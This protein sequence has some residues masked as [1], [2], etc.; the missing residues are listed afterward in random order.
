MVGSRQLGVVGSL[1]AVTTLWLCVA[2]A[3]QADVF[4]GAELRLSTSASGSD[5][6]S[7]REW[8]L[9]ALLPL[10]SDS[11]RAVR[12][13][14][15][16]E[17][18][19]RRSESLG[20]SRLLTLSARCSADPAA[21][22]DAA[23][24][25]R[26]GIDGARLLLDSGGVPAR[27]TLQPTQGLIRIPFRADHSEPSLQRLAPALWQGLL[28]IWLGW[29]HLCF[30]L[31]LC[32]LAPP[33]ALLPLITAF[34]LG[35]SLSLGLAFFNLI[36]LPIGP[37][38]AIIALSIVLLAREAWWAADPQTMPALRRPYLVI[39]V[40]G[41]LHGLGFASAL[42]ALDVAVNARWIVLLGFNLGVE[43]GQVLFIVV[44]LTLFATLGGWPALSRRL[45]A[46]TALSAG[47]I[48]SFWLLE[49][50]LALG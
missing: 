50:L 10:T 12:W 46:T 20:A 2:A 49:R 27:L 7:A 44:V 41:L 15:G 24:E 13:P 26:W 14:D 11:S 17:P 4:S 33:R 43:L 23:I 8:Q 29:D 21:S 30:V 3:A 40:F 6:V 31:L 48:G 16:C 1:R 45:R 38:E 36:R 34:T 32:L 18:L 35:H 5:T 39:T 19:Q 47:S 37:V 28:H 9:E 42:G 25:V 22:A